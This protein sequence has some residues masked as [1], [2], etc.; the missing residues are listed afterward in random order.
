[1]LT[2]QNKDQHEK[3]IITGDINKNIKII[4][5]SDV[6]TLYLSNA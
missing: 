3:T 2:P 4:L 5:T 1:M 6:K